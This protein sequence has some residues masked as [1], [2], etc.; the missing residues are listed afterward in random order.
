MDAM[1]WAKRTPA[2]QYSM[3]GGMR[4]GIRGGS[5]H[6]Q[7]PETGISVLLPNAKAMSAGPVLLLL[8]R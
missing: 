6:V 3:R 5:D 2:A 4:A 1:F 8:R 7:G